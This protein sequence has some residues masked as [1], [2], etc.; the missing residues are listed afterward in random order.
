MVA[1]FNDDYICAESLVLALSHLNKGAWVT[2]PG[3][4]LVM[5][6]H[7]SDRWGATCAK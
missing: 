7:P 6:L 1:V 4:A 2:G 5:V 3:T